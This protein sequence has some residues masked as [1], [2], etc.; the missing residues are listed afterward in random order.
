M[1]KK[2]GTAPW[3]QKQTRDSPLLFWVGLGKD[4][5]E[6]RG[7]GDCVSW[8][9]RAKPH[10]FSLGEYSYCSHY[11]S[12]THGPGREG[13]CASQL[14]LLTLS[15]SVV[16]TCRHW[17]H[18]L[19]GIKVLE[20]LHSHIKGH[21]NLG[22]VVPVWNP[23]TFLKLRQGSCC[24][25]KASLGRL[26]RPCFKTIQN[27]KASKINT[28]VLISLALRD[29]GTCNGMCFRLWTRLSYM[30]YQLIAVC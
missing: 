30:E 18:L 23:N 27:R 25:S 1:W 20:A 11:S 28:P 3:G 16:L 29:H 19:V 26:L 22:M 12:G 8:I 6:C 15:C 10:P 17:E 7:A 2:Q 13:G 21:P 5:R 24:E 4:P 14:S 9:F